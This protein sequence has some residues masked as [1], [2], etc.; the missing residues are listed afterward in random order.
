MADT[1]FVLDKVKVNGEVKPLVAH[2][3]GDHT[4]VSYKGKEMSLNAALASVGEN[5]S[6]V[7]VNVASDSEVKEIFNN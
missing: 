7:D 1:K 3:D 2:S 4:T 5:A 6:K